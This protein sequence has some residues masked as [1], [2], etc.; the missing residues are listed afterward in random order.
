MAILLCLAG[1]GRPPVCPPILWS[2]CMLSPK[3]TAGNGNGDIDRAET[4]EWL[5][6]LEAVLQ[7]EG[8]DRAGFLLSELQHKAV[9]SGVELPFTA[10][11]PYINTIPV[12]RQPPFPGRREIERRIK[13]LVR[14]NAMAI[15]VRAH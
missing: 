6:S 12:S 1:R 2:E 4:S 3:A 10:N 5:E 14:W 13:S 9:R 11:T 15:V 8:R 7:H